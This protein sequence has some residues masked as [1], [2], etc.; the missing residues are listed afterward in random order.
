MKKIV[1]LSIEENLWHN[2]QIY[3]VKNHSKLS[4]TI[5]SLIKNLL[6]EKQENTNPAQ[7]QAKEE[8]NNNVEGHN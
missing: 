6:E 2:F 8:A 5:S 1:S 4:H 3:C 7:D